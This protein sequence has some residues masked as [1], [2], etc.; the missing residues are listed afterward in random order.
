MRRTDSDTDID[1]D[2]DTDT[3]AVPLTLT[4]LGHVL[5]PGC[6]YF[7]ARTEVKTAVML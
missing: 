1:T 5:I 4:L 3:T 2:I 6:R 7:D